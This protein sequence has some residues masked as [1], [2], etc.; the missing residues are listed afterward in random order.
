M[1]GAS[2]D[3]VDEE[4]GAFGSLG[5][6]AGESVCPYRGLRVYKPC[7]LL[8]GVHACGRTRCHFPIR[9][10]NLLCLAYIAMHVAL[11]CSWDC[12]WG[13]NCWGSRL[14]SEIV[15]ICALRGL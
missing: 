8:L 2:V 10:L 11:V 5:S 1:L 14:L 12:W 7:L 6:W 3:A 15:P 4:G 9:G 13:G